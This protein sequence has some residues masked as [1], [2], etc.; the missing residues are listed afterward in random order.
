[1]STEQQIIIST[2]Q[3]DFFNLP[4][5]IAAQAALEHRWGYVRYECPNHIQDFANKITNYQ[6]KELHSKADPIDYRC[7]E[8]GILRSFAAKGDYLIL[9]KIQSA[10]SRYINKSRNQNLSLTI[11]TYTYVVYWPE[12]NKVAAESFSVCQ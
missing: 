3:A 12:S 4:A 11:R 7:K 10:P 2:E 5:A 9:T 1:M 8:A 6:S